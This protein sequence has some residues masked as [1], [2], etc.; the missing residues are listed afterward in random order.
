MRI[1][2][3]WILVLGAVAMSATS[4]RATGIRTGS[5]YGLTNDISSSDVATQWGVCTSMGVSG[6]DLLVQINALELDGVT[7]NPDLGQAIT[8]TLNNVLFIGTPTFAPDEN[9]GASPAFGLIDCSM[10]LDGNFGP[11]AMPPGPCTP[12]AALGENLGCGLTMVSSN[13]FDVLSSCVV[14]G[15]TFYFDVTGTATDI[16]PATISLTSTSAV[17]EPGS[18]ALLAIGLVPMA[19]LSRRRRAWR[20][21]RLG[22]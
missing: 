17:P 10:S 3:A 22:P 6:C 9:G 16:L 14:A 11:N 1:K 12:A 2:L 13:S 5:N 21:S 4:V 18:L 15:E 19:A 7:P 20:K 8:I